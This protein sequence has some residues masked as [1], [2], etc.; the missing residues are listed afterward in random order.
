MLAL[1]F[2]V[3]FGVTALW[4]FGGWGLLLAEAFTITFWGTIEACML[5]ECYKMYV[6]SSSAEEE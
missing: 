3:Y 5:P 4:A 6:K 2:G 1:I